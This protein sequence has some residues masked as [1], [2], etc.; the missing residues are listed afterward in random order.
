MVVSLGGILDE[1]IGA[2]GL[3]IEESSRCSTGRND[4]QPPT[5]L[6]APTALAMDAAIGLAGMAFQPRP[7]NV[8]RLCIDPLLR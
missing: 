8:C 1:G 2:N 7:R 5:R 6:V 3:L 4:Y